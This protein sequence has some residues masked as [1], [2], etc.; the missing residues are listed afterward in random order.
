[1][2]DEKCAQFGDCCADSQFRNS[3]SKKENFTCAETAFDGYVYMKTFCPPSWNET[4]IK[5]NCENRNISL[6][7]TDVWLS[8]PVINV[9]TQVSYR[10]A[11]CALCNGEYEF[12]FWL[13]GISCD[14]DTVTDSG[15]STMDDILSNLSLNDTAEWFWMYKTTNSTRRCAMQ[16]KLPIGGEEY[17]RYCVPNVVDTCLPQWKDLSENCSSYASYAY[18]ENK[19]FKNPTCLQCNNVFLPTSCSPPKL[20]IPD[21]SYT[22]AIDGKIPK[23]DH[24]SEVP[25]NSTPYT[26][27]CDTTAAAPASS[28]KLTVDE[29]CYPNTKCKI[30]GKFTIGTEIV[31]VDNETVYLKAWDVKYPDAEFVET[32]NQTIYVCGSYIPRTKTQQFFDVLDDW[33]SEILV[34]FS[35]IFLLLHLLIFQQL[36]EMKNLSGKTLAVFCVT[37]LIALSCFE[38]GPLL[39]RCEIVAMLQHYMFMSCFMWMLIMSYDCWLSMYRATKKFRQSGGKHMGKFLI[40]CALAWAIPLIVVGAGVYAQFAP[41]NTIS[42]EWKPAYG[43]YGQCFI[44]Q[45]KGLYVFFFLPATC[46]FLGNI[47]FFAH[48]AYMIYLSQRKTV[49]PNTRNDFQLYTRLALMMGLTWTLGSILTIYDNIVLAL[50]FSV[51]NMSQGI[52]I[53]FAFTFKEK[54]LKLLLN[55]HQDNSFI[56]STLSTLVSSNVTDTPAPAAQSQN[57]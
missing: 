14:D 54:T 56:S 4:V 48:T 18:T 19:A 10:N 24:C 3:D 9:S 38:V 33:L 30:N 7:N 36:P 1:M 53:F 26:M 6:L 57:V 23:I 49:N 46:M 22:I 31:Y 39:P 32:D 15:N 41:T 27:L 25:K 50:L 29:E 17:V 40:Y 21:V 28:K 37:L 12:A 35:I 20:N 51:F 44:G 43:K 45:V 11:F 42:C 2:C 47:G 8:T 34:K 55:K 52:F 16:G 5:Q 13:V